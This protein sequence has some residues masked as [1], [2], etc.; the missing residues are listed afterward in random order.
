MGRKT[1]EERIGE[2]LRFG[3]RLGL[4]RITEL[5]HR[6]GDPQDDLEV[7]HIAGTN[8]KGSTSRYIYETLIE[9]GYNAGIYTSP[10][11]EKF[12]ERIE[13]GRHVISD[14]DLEE[15]TDVVLEK[16]S[17]MVDEG[18]ESPTEFEVVTAVAFVWFKKI[19]CNV[20][21]L[22]VGL[23]G[24]GDSTNII[25][26]PVITVITS[27]SYDHMDRLGSTIT[28]IASEKAGIIKKGCPVVVSTEREAAL[29]VFSDKASELGAPL[30]D[31]R[32][33]ASYT[34]KELRPGGSTFDYSADIGGSHV[35]MNG[36]EISMGGE[37]QV[38]NAAEAITALLVQDRFDISEEA[39]RRGLGKAKQP[40]RFEIL[41]DPN[42][43][44]FEQ[45][46]H[47]SGHGTGNPWVIIDGAHNQDAA[48]RL[49]AAMGQFFPGRRVLFVCGILADKDVSGIL[50]EFTEIGTDFVATEPEN[51]RKLSAYE[52]A[53][54][55]N[56]RGKMVYEIPKPKDAAALAMSIAKG[57]DVVL[58]TGSLYLIGMIRKLL[59]EKYLIK[60][61]VCFDRPDKDDSISAGIDED[62]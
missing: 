56:S 30:Y 42:E 14:E 2:F 61:N 26:K 20:A 5:M 58:F 43:D 15:C 44:A 54:A 60:G 6:L 57:Y 8:G 17:Q 47:V 29:K 1:A 11:I 19:G 41:Y 45:N 23:G 7:I 50:D 22:E 53:K 27:I 55:I 21:V 35:S 9:A 37:H 52:L 34:I 28:E 51:E 3:S 59:R 31:T 46:T 49:R 32:K 38:I 16:V 4:E 10:F 12:N 48:K 13:A 40:G 18:M 62:D 33:L 39:I 36:I 24:R 25:K